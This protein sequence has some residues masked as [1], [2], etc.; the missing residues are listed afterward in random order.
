MNGVKG[1]QND[2]VYTYK[3]KLLFSYANYERGGRM[4]IVPRIED[5][6]K[7]V[8]T[9]SEWMESVGVS[10]EDADAFYCDHCPERDNDDFPWGCDK[11]CSN[12]KF[13]LERIEMDAEVDFGAFMDLISDFQS[14]VSSP[15][16]EE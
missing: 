6:H 16:E 14:S 13:Q 4:R 12:R 9:V 15:R 5:I 3:T 8:G 10:W 7:Y 2:S 11:L 1:R